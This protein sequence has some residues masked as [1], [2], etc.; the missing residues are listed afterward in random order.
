MA[1]NESL[2]PQDG[3]ASPYNKLRERLDDGESLEQLWPAIE[4]EFYKH[5]QRVWRSLREKKIDFQQ[6]LSAAMN[7]PKA[8]ACLLRQSGNNPAVKLLGEVAENDSYPNEEQLIMAFL[9]E[10]WEAAANQMQLNRREALESPQT[11]AL[12][13]RM[14]TRIADSL[15]GNPSR[16]PK[17]ALNS[18]KVLSL[19]SQLSTSL[20]DF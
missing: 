17:R 1:E 10:L 2:I 16:F 15:C 12:V 4:T 9:Y 19:D 11:V 18:E 3:A 6:V 20:L 5:G 13:Q 14:L 7:N 8:L